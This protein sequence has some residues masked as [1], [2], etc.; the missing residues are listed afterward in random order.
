MQTCVGVQGVSALSYRRRGIDTNFL[1]L[2]E[3]LPIASDQILRIDN[4]PN[5]PEAGSLQV[6]VTGSK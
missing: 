2:R 4:D 1:P 3:T 6:T 5:R